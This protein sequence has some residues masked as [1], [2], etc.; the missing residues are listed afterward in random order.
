MAFAGAPVGVTGKYAKS[1]RVKKTAETDTSVSYV[2]L[3]QQG[4]ISPGTLSL[5]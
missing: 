1:W 5:I 4:W 3:M 2:I